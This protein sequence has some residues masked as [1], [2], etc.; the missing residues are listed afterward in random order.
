MAFDNLN[1]YAITRVEDV[2]VRLR[3]D[4]L[5][6]IERHKL[7]LD[8]LLGSGRTAG[9]RLQECDALDVTWRLVLEYL[10][11][12]EAQLM[13]LSDILD[14][15]DVIVD[16]R[17]DPLE[18][19]KILIF[20]VFRKLKKVIRKVRKRQQAGHLVDIYIGGEK[21]ATGKIKKFT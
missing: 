16:A 2:P 8:I 19:G 14:D 6:T 3:L 1:P 12:T 4:K 20:E 15:P 13:A 21:V 17:C 5:S 9:L 18:E 7:A 10:G 11:Q